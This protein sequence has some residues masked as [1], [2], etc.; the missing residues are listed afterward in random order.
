M[1]AAIANYRI[2]GSRCGMGCCDQAASEELVRHHVLQGANII[3]RHAPILT[4]TPFSLLIVDNLA[5]PLK[6]PL[7]PANFVFHITINIPLDQ[8]GP[9]GNVSSGEVA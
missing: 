8:F 3:L 9:I 7:P 1:D 6:G 4:V 2:S 5:Q